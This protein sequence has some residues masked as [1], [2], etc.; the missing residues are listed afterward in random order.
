MQGLTKGRR[1]VEFAAAS[2][3]LGWMI[4][5]ILMAMYISAYRCIT[6]KDNAFGLN[7]LMA[8]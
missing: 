2:E 6:T 8:I 7:M 5:S 4:Q 1:M 3:Q